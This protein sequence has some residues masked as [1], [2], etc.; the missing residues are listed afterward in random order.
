MK[1]RWI[2]LLLA[3]VLPIGVLA[4][5]GS[6]DM[7]ELSLDSITAP[8][9]ARN[10]MEVRT[11][12]GNYTGI[13]EAAPDSADGE[14][15]TVQFAGDA[16]ATTALHDGYIYVLSNSELRILRAAGASTTQL[17]T[18]D[19]SSGTSSEDSYEFANALL[20]EGDRLAV[21]T[22]ASSMDSDLSGSDV[23]HL[24]LYD[25]SEPS[26]P[27]LLRTFSQ[28]GLYE[29]IGTA[30]GLLFLVSSGTADLDEASGSAASMPQI[31][32][33]AES[34]AVPAAQFYLSSALDAPTFSIVSAISLADAQR[35]GVRAFTGTI[36]HVCVSE[37]GVF[38][39]RSIRM[40]SHGDAY[41]K[42]HY[43][44][45]NHAI[46]AATELLRLTADADLTMLASKPLAGEVAAWELN[47]QANA[48][49]VVRSLSSSQYQLFE[50]KTYGWTNRLDQSQ[51]GG[52]ALNVLDLSLQQIADGSDL[53]PDAALS[54]ARFSGN[55]C[56]LAMF[57]ADTPLAAIDLSNATKP[58]LAEVS[59][60]S[61]LF[62]VLLPAEGMLMD[63]S[64][65]NG[66]NGM[67]LAI[68]TMA[69][70]GG[71]VSA[72]GLVKELGT[73]AGGAVYAAV[74][75][76]A[77]WALVCYDHTSHLFRLGDAITEV[78]RP[79]ISVHSGTA[80]FFEG[81]YLYACAPDEVSAVSLTS[82]SV[83]ALLSF[84]VG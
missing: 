7:P 1:K 14:M 36:D 39:A 30:N 66:A 10:E 22:T 34:E 69:M 28:D 78:S 77:A 62:N 84:A 31:G 50:D 19:I 71:S 75:Q 33:N 6:E 73:Y 11:A 17:N 20:V 57:D 24:R 76:D 44:V 38:L 40:E 5:C 35:S 27:T 21:V 59:G 47:A 25:I 51:N 12:L 41:K 4:G 45:T 55:Y 13:S 42:D 68:S 65:A 52:T 29:G 43:S 56:L 49:Y 82:G 2:A 15:A 60:L 67:S 18:L 46:N 83:D 8:V 58:A 61:E 26:T 79:E 72:T 48:L 3:A 16:S 37:Q 63:L 53:L 32:D 74:S 54:A 64:G 70:G 9:A 80:F 81:D 23:C